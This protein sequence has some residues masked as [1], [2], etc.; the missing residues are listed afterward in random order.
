MTTIILL[1]IENN[2]L[3]GYAAVLAASLLAVITAALMLKYSTY[4]VAKLSKSFVR[5]LGRSVLIMIAA[6]AFEMIKN[7]IAE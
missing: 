3:E 6:M 4:I 1:V 5:G 2:T 7:R